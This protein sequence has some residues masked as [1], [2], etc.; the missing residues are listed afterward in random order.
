MRCV[1][2]VPSVPTFALDNGFWYSATEAQ[3][4]LLEVG[5]LV[6]VPLSGRRVR[7][8]VVEVGD[9]PPQG[10][11]PVAAISMPAPV[12][13]QP[14]LSA[15]QWAAQRYVAPLAVLLERSTP[16]NLVRRSGFQPSKPV[17]L[18]A[19][20]PAHPLGALA[21]GAATGK[22]HPPVALI[23]RWSNLD[24]MEGLARPQLAAHRS[25]MVVTATAEEAAFLH[26]TCRDLFGEERSVL[27]T[28]DRSEAENTAAWMAAQA[29]GVVV[30]GTPRLAGWKVKDLTVAAVVEEGRRAMKDRQTPTIHVRDLLRTRARFGRHNLVFVGPTPSLETLAGGASPVRMSRRAWPPVEI[31]DRNEEPPLPGVVGHQAMAAI[32]A[33]VARSGSVFVFAHRR[34]YAPA[35]RCDKCRSL[36]RCP[37]CGSRPEAAPDCPRCDFRLG[38]C[39]DCGHDRFVPLGAGVGRVVEELRR[40]WREGVAAAP[41]VAPVVVGSEADLAGLAAVDLAVAV[42]ADGLIL[43]SHFR[44]GEEALRILA[45]LAG[46]VAPGSGKRALVQ[47]GLPSHPVVVALRKGDPLVFLE[48]EMEQR[49]Q[50]GFPPSSELMV[51]EM[52]GTVPAGAEDAIRA[53]AGKAVVMGPAPRPE[54]R[55]RWLVQGGDL[56]SFRHDL[57]PLVQ[58]WRDSGTTVRIDTDPIDL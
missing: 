27:V 36:R 16:P 22:R 26:E 8:F 17:E 47:T 39:S 9:R 29:G 21:A 2:V 19:T 52:R 1:R 46:R 41:D 38:P 24:W 10:L 33:V 30:I 32:R 3:A 50:L 28:P 48:A 43:G 53:A 23:E 12:F 58:R 45:R 44:A 7:G 13:D 11:K 34:G 18:L 14:L 15:L 5:S 35:V 31:A 42:D 51:V 20:G 4:P 25:M 54:R 37:N 40:T 6:R 55:W 56:T 57:R 49:R